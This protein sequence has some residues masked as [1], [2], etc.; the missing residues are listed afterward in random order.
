MA[1]NISSAVPVGKSD[2]L[3]KKQE[4]QAEKQYKQILENILSGQLDNIK[5]VK[6]EPQQKEEEIPQ[7][8]QV[9][10][11][12]TPLPLSEIAEKLNAEG[13]SIKV[14]SPKNTYK[15]TPMV[16]INK[17]NCLASWAIAVLLGIECLF[18]YL[19]FKNYADVN[20]SPFVII[21]T[22][23]LLAP[24]FLT[25][26]N[27]HNPTK[28]VKSKFNFRFNFVNAWIFFAMAFIIDL[29]VYFLII[30]AGNITEFCMYLIL[31]SVL[32]LNA[33]LSVYIYHLINKTM[34]NK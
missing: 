17:L 22:L 27:F 8:K 21:V 26:N 15:P 1:Q 10:F 19:V 20:L 29:I 33:P 23:L 16:F 12:N 11:T 18:M 13:V 5:N 4:S 6:S 34:L 31:P 14:Y 25:V 3:I 9:Q 30:G 28:K 24:I 32:C 7:Q 2:T